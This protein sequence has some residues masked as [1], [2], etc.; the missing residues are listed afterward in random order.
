MIFLIQ[1]V[2]SEGYKKSAINGIQIVKKLINCDLTYENGVFNPYNVLLR[3][4]LFVKTNL[5]N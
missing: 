2:Q 1:S 3:N 5:K 4:V